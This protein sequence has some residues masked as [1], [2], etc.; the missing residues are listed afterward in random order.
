[1]VIKKK[2]L[3][4]HVVEPKHLKFKHVPTKKKREK[5][6][7]RCIVRYKRKRQLGGFLNRYDFAYTGRDVVNQEGKVTPGIIKGA[8]GNINKIVKQRINQIISQG[9]KEIDRILPNVLRGAIEDVYQTPFRLLRNFGK[10]Q[11]NKPKQKILKQQIVG[12]NSINNKSNN[13]YTFFVLNN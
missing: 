13:N 4:F 6:I 7:R 3:G 9:R 8:T 2:P 10:S 5:Q 11:F 1:M 12:N